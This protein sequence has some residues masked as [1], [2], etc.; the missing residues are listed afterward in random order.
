MHI[1]VREVLPSG[2]PGP[3]R[4]Q[5]SQKRGLMPRW[6]PD[7]GEI[8]YFDPPNMMAVEVRVDGPTFVAGTPKPIG[9]PMAGNRY[10]VTRDGQ[11]FL[12]AAPVKPIESIR[13]LVNW[14]PESPG[15]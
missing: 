2:E 8:F 13:V 12:F 14:R 7:G 4:W 6:R 9:V 5:I 15:R 11:R 3:G 10:F 1:F